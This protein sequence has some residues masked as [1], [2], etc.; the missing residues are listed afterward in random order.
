MDTQP[1]FLWIIA[2]AGD[3]QWVVGCRCRLN[4]LRFQLVNR[5]CCRWLPQHF[6]SIEQQRG[7]RVQRFVHGL[8]AAGAVL[9]SQLTDDFS[10]GH[11]VRRQRVALLRLFAQRSR[12]AIQPFGQASY[13][14]CNIDQRHVARHQP[15]KLMACSHQLF[16][17]RFTYARALPKIL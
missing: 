11:V 8:N 2:A 14:L 4:A 12:G 6:E 7:G 1:V 17:V 13:H 5:C 16:V 10:A 3:Y 9:P 15:C